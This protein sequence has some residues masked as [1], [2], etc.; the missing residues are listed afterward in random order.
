MAVTTPD[1]IRKV[2]IFT[3]QLEGATRLTAGCALN[4]LGRN[5]RAGRNGLNVA[6]VSGLAGGG[7]GVAGGDELVGHV[8]PEVPGG[9]AAHH[10]VPLDFL[11]AANF[12]PPGT[13]P[14]VEVPGHI[15]VY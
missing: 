5:W 3:A 8:A 1:G 14:R 11:G 6:E 13:A 15:G 2:R 7:K 10:P 9:N 12:G 4:I